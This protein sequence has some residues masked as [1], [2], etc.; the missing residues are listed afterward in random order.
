MLTCPTIAGMLYYN[1]KYSLD[2]SSL[3]IV[4]FSTLMTF[5][6]VKRDNTRNYI[7]RLPEFKPFIGLYGA[8]YTA[9]YNRRTND[10]EILTGQKGRMVSH[11]CFGRFVRSVEGK[12]RV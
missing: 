9:D 7:F 6:S 8:N 12:N 3:Q 10:L 2:R 1:I 11:R 5:I 4:S